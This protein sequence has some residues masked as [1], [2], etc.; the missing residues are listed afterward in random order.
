MVVVALLAAAQVAVAL[1][2]V[3]EAVASAVEMECDLESSTYG[4][5]LQP[6]CSPTT[7]RTGTASRRERAPYR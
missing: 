4:S 2:V 3:R 7:V 1:E 6:A 5:R